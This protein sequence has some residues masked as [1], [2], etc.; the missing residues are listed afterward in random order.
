MREVSSDAGKLDIVMIDESTRIMKFEIDMLIASILPIVDEKTRVVLIGDPCQTKITLRTLPCTAS[1]LTDDPLN[2]SALEWILWLAIYEDADPNVFVDC[3]DLLNRYKDSLRCREEACRAVNSLTELCLPGK[4][5]LWNTMVRGKKVWADLTP[6]PSSSL[7]RLDAFRRATTPEVVA[8]KRMRGEKERLPSDFSTVGYRGKSRHDHDVALYSA[9]TAV[10]MRVC[11]RRQRRA[12]K[13]KHQ[14]FDITEETARTWSDAPVD[15]TIIA[16]Y[17]SM[18][19]L[20]R[21]AVEFV[22]WLLRWAPRRSREDAG[23]GSLTVT[24]VS[25]D[26]VQGETFDHAVLA[27]PPQTSQWS[28]YLCDPCRQMVLLSRHKVQVAIS[29]VVDDGL[30]PQTNSFGTSV[31][32]FLELQARAREKWSWEKMT[33]TLGLDSAYDDMSWAQWLYWA[34]WWN[35]TWSSSDCSS[36]EA[37][38]AVTW[39]AETASTREIPVFPSPIAY[40]GR[41]LVSLRLSLIHI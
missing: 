21:L 35:S 30:S 26:S 11:E 37:Q 1:L 17:A 22:Q 23:E 39:N 8:I 19:D 5:D 27:L 9:L 34:T 4:P 15:V 7:A 18:V 10:F 40:R 36:W 14:H 38:A 2:I 29:P 31:R 6:Q 20:L 24:S 28:P 12:L 3:A 16:A 32:A 41:K 13:E 33:K 25:L